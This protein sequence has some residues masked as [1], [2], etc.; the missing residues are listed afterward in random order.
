MNNLTRH[1]ATMDISKHIQAGRHFLLFFISTLRLFWIFQRAL[2][3]QLSSITH[4]FTANILVRSVAQ[5]YVAVKAI[6]AYLH[7]IFDQF[8]RTNRNLRPE[9]IDSPPNPSS[10]LVGYCHYS[11]LVKSTEWLKTISFTASI[12]SKKAVFRQIKS[13]PLPL[14]YP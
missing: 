8:R 10:Y 6:R 12:E 11:D 1:P 13:I 14:K 2:K 5:W 4:G 9:T 7:I 3:Q